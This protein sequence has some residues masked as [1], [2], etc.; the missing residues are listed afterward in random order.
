MKE[1]KIEEIMGGM[2]CP[3]GFESCKSGTEVPCKPRLLADGAVVDCTEAECSNKV[4]C[5]Y[6]MAFG[7]G[8]LCN[9]P[10]RTYMAGEL[11]K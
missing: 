8:H 2:D 1:R 7:F 6:R 5:K 11:R 4:D 10:V 9:C 3:R